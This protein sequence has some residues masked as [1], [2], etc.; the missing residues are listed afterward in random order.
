MLTP[1]LAQAAG[2]PEIPAGFLAALI[3]VLVGMIVIGLIIGAI[4]AFLIY[5]P[6][7]KLPAEHQTIAPGLCFL[8]LVPVANL[9]MPIILGTKIPEAFANH[10]A[11]TGQSAETGDAGK[12]IGLWWGI[13]TLCCIVPLVNMIAGLAALV[14]LIIFIIKLWDMAK[15]IDTGGNM[16]T[17]DGP[18]F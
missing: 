12:S 16:A 17:P 4:V 18:T 3:G 6:Y 10:F 9:V 13:S 5:K 15:R 7:S 2:Q 1:L 11:T 8:L 14:L